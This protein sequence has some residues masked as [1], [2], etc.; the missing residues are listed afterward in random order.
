MT[1]HLFSSTTLLNLFDKAVMKL[2]IALMLRQH[3][4][5]AGAQAFGLIYHGARFYPEGFGFIARGDGARGIGFDR[6]NR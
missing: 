2:D 1:I 6:D 5:Q 4:D 3:A